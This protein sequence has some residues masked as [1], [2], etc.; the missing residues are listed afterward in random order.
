VVTQGIL[1]LSSGVERNQAQGDVNTVFGLGRTQTQQAE[2]VTRYMFSN[3]LESE[4]CAECEQFDGTI[5][6]ASELE[7]FATP[8]SECEGGDKCNC[9]ILSVPPGE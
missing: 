6:G 3:L 1:D 5:F 8:F 9:L 2:G 7:F 4:T